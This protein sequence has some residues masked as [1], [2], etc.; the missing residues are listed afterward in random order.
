MI[1]LKK[2][3]FLAMQKE[4]QIWLCDILFKLWFNWQKRMKKYNAIQSFLCVH[5]IV[6]RIT[7]EGIRNHPWFQVN[8]ITVLQGVE[9]E[10]SLDDVHAVFD[11]IEVRFSPLR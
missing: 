3:R 11:D 10:L 9:E 1:L 7:I 2:I 4:P 6:Q 8:Y 5:L